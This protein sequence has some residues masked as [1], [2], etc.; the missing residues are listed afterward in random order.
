MLSEPPAS[1]ARHGAGAQDRIPAVNLA[2]A[3]WLAVV[4]ACAIAV[5]ILLSQDYYG[6]AVVTLAVGLSAAINLR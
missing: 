1:A 2:R 6:Y 3:A 5:V 4:M